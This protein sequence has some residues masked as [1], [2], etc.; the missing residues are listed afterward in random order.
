MLDYPK[1]VSL[2]VALVGLPGLGGCLVGCNLFDAHVSQMDVIR[3]M[4]VSATERLKDGSLTQISASGQALNPGI[5]VEAGIIYRATARYDGLGGQFS[6][7]SQGEMGR[8]VDQEAIMAIYRRADIS[9]A[10][11]IE[12][13]RQLLESAGHLD[14]GPAVPPGTQP[15]DTP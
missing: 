11:K 12:L 13:I 10:Q 1:L 15:L 7:S 14:R 6:I 2:F 3:G 4:A 8:A 9:E 5:V